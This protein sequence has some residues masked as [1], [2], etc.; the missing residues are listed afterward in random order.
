MQLP[1]ARFSLT[2]KNLSDLLGRFAE[3]LLESSYQFVVL[4]FRISQIVIR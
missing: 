4:A 3:L 1:M 2:L